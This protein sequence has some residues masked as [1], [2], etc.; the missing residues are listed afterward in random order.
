MEE[1][2]LLHYGVLGMKW[3]VRKAR[4]TTKKYAK[5][6]RRALVNYDRAKALSSTGKKTG[7]TKL[8]DSANEYYSKAKKYQ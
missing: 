7:N 5:A 2:Y 8:S 3:G 1:E 4:R 6:Q